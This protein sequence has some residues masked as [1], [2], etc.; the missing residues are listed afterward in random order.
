MTLTFALHASGADRGSPPT[1]LKVIL[2]NNVLQRVLC[3]RSADSVRTAFTIDQA[4]R[5]YIVTARHVVDGIASASA[6]SVRRERRWVELPV[7]V[8]GMGE[9]A[10]CP[11]ARPV[12][13]LMS[14]AVVV[15]GVGTS[16]KPEQD[17]WSRQGDRRAARGRSWAATAGSFSVGVV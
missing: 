13:A 15:D 17:G 10:R 16:P 12:N 14:A 9:T 4:E 5:Q 7:T 2:T 11:A 1:D 6:V 8:V 3:I